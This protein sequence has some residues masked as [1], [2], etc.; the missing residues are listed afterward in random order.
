MG[1]W[2]KRYSDTIFL[3]AACLMVTVL[4]RGQ[5]TSLHKA[6]QRQ[7]W[8]DQ[9]VILKP[10][11]A[12]SLVPIE[13]LATGMKPLIA[14]FYWIKAQTLNSDQIFEARK[15]KAAG[16]S[17]L[18]LQ[19]AIQRTPADAREL[20][21]L[22]RMATNLDPSFE[23]AYFYGSTILSWDEQVPLAL[24][25]LQRGV[26]ANPKSAKLASSISFLYFY[27]LDDWEKGA[28]YAKISYENS[29]KYSSTPKAVVSMYSA[30]RSFD[31]AINYLT[32]VLEGTEDPNT[33]GEIENQLALLVV[34]KHIEFLEGALD[35]IK[36]RVGVYPASLEALVAA[37]FIDEIP[38]EPF[39]GKYVIAEP[40]RVENEPR[41]RND[42]YTEMKEYREKTPAGGRKRL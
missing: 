34:E 11:R 40:G 35:E 29:G 18:M 21:D 37:G 5:V 42:H 22:L 24:S 4:L 17:G 28:E 2:L 12:S 10:T 6:W 25:L 26:E 39:G 41:I 23:Y 1:N 32:D 36:N 15:E 33:K 38:E 9:A 8:A 7:V 31:L 3:L 14:D 19:A 27:F 13:I 16:Q 20:Y 30:G